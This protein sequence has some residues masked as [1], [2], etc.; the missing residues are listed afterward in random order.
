MR[1]VIVPALL[2]CLALCG[3][4]FRPTPT[5]KPLPTLTPTLTTVPTETQRPP[6]ATR[7]A[8]RVRTPTASPTVGVYEVQAGDV[9]GLIAQ[10]FGITLE[11]LCAANGIT[12]ADLIGIGQTLVIPPRAS[13]TPGP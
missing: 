2:A 7:T 9:L 3:C 11:Q 13:P 4:Y 5:P 6:T 12:D 8:T 10:R 1:R